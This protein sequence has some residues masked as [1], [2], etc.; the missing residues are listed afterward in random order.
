MDGVS[1]APALTQGD[2]AV[3]HDK[4]FIT[5]SDLKQEGRWRSP[6]MAVR[7]QTHTYVEYDTRRQPELYDIVKDPK[8]KNNL[9]GTAEGDGLLPELKE[10][11]E[12]LKA[13]RK[14]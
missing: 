10:T 2:D 1:W 14:S 8:Q 9:I 7:T 5:G 13:G 3:V 11:L 6:E 12:G 4:L